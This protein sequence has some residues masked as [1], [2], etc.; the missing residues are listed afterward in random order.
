MVLNILHD[1]ITEKE[2]LKLSNSEI[3]I[4]VNAILAIK[5]EQPITFDYLDLSNLNLRYLTLENVTFVRCNLARA[6]FGRTT[7]NNCDF[8]SCYLVHSSFDNISFNSF[9]FYNCDLSFAYFSNCNFDAYT[10]SSF[11]DLTRTIFEDKKNLDQVFFN[12]YCY[13]KERPPQFNSDELNKVFEIDI[14][15]SYEWR[16]NKN[17]KKIRMRKINDPNNPDKT[18][19]RELGWLL[20][21]PSNQG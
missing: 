18:V 1:H 2:G 11:G 14:A 6:S 10:H 4:T 16:K 13:E 19:L 3:E 20:P 12:S 5:S 21:Q 7:F 17:G 9:G 8:R 15:Q